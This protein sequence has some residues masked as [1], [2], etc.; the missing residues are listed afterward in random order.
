MYE[1]FV[2]EITLFAGS[3][4][5]KNWALCDGSILPVAQNTILYSLLLN[6]YGGEG[7]TTFALPNLPPQ[8]GVRY[9]IATGG[10]Y[11]PFPQPA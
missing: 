3:R 9:I 7:T 5:P 1:P 8:G 10:F 2:G 11:P 4:V 6:T